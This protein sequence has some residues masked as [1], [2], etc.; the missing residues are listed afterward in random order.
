MDAL[1][2]VDGN[3]TSLQNMTSTLQAL[4]NDVA[5]EMD[6]LVTSCDAAGIISVNCM[7]AVDADAIRNALLANFGNVRC[8]SL[9]Q[10]WLLF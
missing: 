1:E 8:H 5:D 6:A 3:V 7:N 10:S 9:A 4:L 2:A